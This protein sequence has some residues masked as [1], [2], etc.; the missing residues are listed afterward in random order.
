VP[1]MTKGNVAVLE[2]PSTDPAL[3]TGEKRNKRGRKPASEKANGVAKARY[4]LL[5]K[6]ADRESGKLALGEEFE[7]EDKALVRSHY[8]VSV[9]SRLYGCINFA[10]S[11]KNGGVSLLSFS[12]YDGHQQAMLLLSAT[13]EFVTVAGVW[14]VSNSGREELLQLRTDR[15]YLA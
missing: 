6:S 3:G 9:E 4:F 7:S 1:E 5:A 2:G 15:E 8:L 13:G 11:W 14:H 10:S 12:E